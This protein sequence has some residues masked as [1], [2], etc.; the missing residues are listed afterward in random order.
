MKAILVTILLILIPNISANAAPYEYSEAGIS[1]D[2]R[3]LT[4][5]DRSN[6]NHPLSVWFTAGKAPFSVSVVFR[7]E[8]EPI[9]DFIKNQEN[10][11]RIGGYQKEVTILKK[12]IS[13]GTAYEIIRVSAEVKIRWFIFQSRKDGRAYSFWL[14]ENQNMKTENQQAVN[15]YETMKSTLVVS[16]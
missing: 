5:T 12:P 9:A 1:F 2:H 4:V 16:K 3:N 11:I 13:S 10:E 6:E 7:S 8:G 14:V 15:A